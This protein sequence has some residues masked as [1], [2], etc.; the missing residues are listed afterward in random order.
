MCIGFACGQIYGQLSMHTRR[1]YE[2]RDLHVPFSMLWQGVTW[3]SH[4]TRQLS[5]ILNKP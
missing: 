5:Y 4:K 2:L 1:A 3:L